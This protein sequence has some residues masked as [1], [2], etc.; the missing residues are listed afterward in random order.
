MPSPYHIPVLSVHKALPPIC[1]FHQQL[2]LYCFLPLF[3]L[4]YCYMSFVYC[5]TLITIYTCIICWLIS[6]EGM[7]I[8][9]R[10]LVCSSVPTWLLAT[11]CQSNAKRSDGFFWLLQASH[12]HVVYL[13]KYRENGKILKHL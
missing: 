10:T 4:E 8:L 5:N 12:T 6:Y 7:L 2:H 13:H 11:I 9:Q 3:I 1:H